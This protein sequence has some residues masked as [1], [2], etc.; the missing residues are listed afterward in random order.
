V[1]ASTLIAAVVFNPARKRVQRVV[2]RRFNGAHY[3]AEAT[4]AAFASCLRESVDLPSIERELIAA[5]H[6]AKLMPA[7]L[8]MIRE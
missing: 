3:D 8:S 7:G 6:Q 5:V 4:V 1:A 2:D